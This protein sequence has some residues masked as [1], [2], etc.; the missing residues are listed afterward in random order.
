LRWT[1]EPTF[2]PT[3]KPTRT[4]PPAGPPAGP[5]TGPPAG[6]DGADGGLGRRWATTAPLPARRPR[7][8]V[9]AKQRLEARRCREGST[10]EGPGGPL[11]RPVACGPCS[12]GRT[13]W[14]DP[15]GCAC[16][17][18]S[19]ASWRDDGCSAGTYACSRRSPVSTVD[20]ARDRACR[21]LARRS[22][23][24]PRE[25]VD[26]ERHAVPHDRFGPLNGT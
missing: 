24:R 4:G 9:S 16:A 15:R 17:G 13:R 12:G 20:E 1:A 6:P 19:R 23:G 10:T 22:L 5:P 3:T 2:R 14:R 8:T 26:E 11:R 25:I 18:G 7:R 21:V